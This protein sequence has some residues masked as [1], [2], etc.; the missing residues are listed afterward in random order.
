MPRPDG[1]P[2]DFYIS[3]WE[4]VGEL[5][6]DAIADF[7]QCGRLLKEANNTI[8]S[9]IP[10]TANLSSLSD[11]RPISC[12]NT[13]YK[14]IAKILARRMAQ[15]LPSVIG[16]EQSAFIP[17]RR[18]SD[19]ILLAQELLNSYNARKGPARCAMKIDITKAFD[20]VE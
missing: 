4:T 17:G 19:N 5:V 9:L 14:C 6:T 18:I 1:Y 3:S 12:C 15:V 16:N 20:S 10:K 7:F 11:Y 2:V 13:V 8:L